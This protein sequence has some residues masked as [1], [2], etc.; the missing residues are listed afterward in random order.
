[1]PATTPDLLAVT[2]RHGSLWT[3]LGSAIY[4]RTGRS[5]VFINGT[6]GGAQLGDLLDD[7]SDY[8]RR[9]AGQAAIARRIDLAPDYVFWIQGETDASG[10]VP[11]GT[12]WVVYRSTHCK[13]RRDDGDHR[14]ISASVV[15]A[16][17]NRGAINPPPG[18]TAHRSL[19][20]RKIGNFVP[21][22]PRIG[23]YAQ[24]CPHCPAGAQA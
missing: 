15:I 17:L 5:V 19:G 6:V 2:G 12:P 9:L 1:M 3:G 4:G 10:A 18:S 13:D 7:R 11:P 24:R 22:G 14:A 8:L 23:Q 20:A 21:A 16:R